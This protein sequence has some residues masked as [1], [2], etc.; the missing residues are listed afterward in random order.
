MSD[1]AVFLSQIGPSSLAP[2]QLSISHPTSLSSAI[3]VS[4]TTDN[5]ATPEKGDTERSVEAEAAETPPPTSTTTTSTSSACVQPAPRAAKPV[6]V[7]KKV[8]CP[9][10]TAVWARALSRT[11]C[12]IYPEVYRGEGLGTLGVSHNV[13][14]SYERVV[15]KKFYGYKGVPTGTTIYIPLLNFAQFIKDVFLKLPMDI[16]V[17]LVVGQEDGTFSFCSF[18][19]VFIDLLFF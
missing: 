4:L 14:R 13:L 3:D 6:S 16:K 19:F 12:D 7:F 9:L 10:T 2:E 11:C 1:D 18:Q 15:G 8:D 5:L 17:V